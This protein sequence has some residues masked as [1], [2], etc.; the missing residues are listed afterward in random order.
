MLNLFLLI[1]LINPF[2]CSH[3]LQPDPDSPLINEAE[4]ISEGVIRQVTD[5]VRSAPWKLRVVVWLEGG[6]MD[7][8]GYLVP[9]N[10][11]ATL[12]FKPHGSL[13]VTRDAESNQFKYKVAGLQDGDREGHLSPYRFSERHFTVYP[14]GPLGIPFYILLEA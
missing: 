11:V 14:G 4:R 2:D 5:E 12:K 1:G 6:P 13:V 10:D 9:I 8:F 3:I 7:V